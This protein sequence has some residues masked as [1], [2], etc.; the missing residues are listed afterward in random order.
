MA[1]I[2]KDLVSQYYGRA[3]AY[4]YFSGCSTGGRQGITSAVEYPGDFDGILAGA[5]AL[6]LADLSVAGYWPQFVMHHEGVY[7]HRCEFDAILDAEIAACDGLDGVEDGIISDPDA[8]V[9]DPETLVGTTVQC[10]GNLTEGTPTSMKISEAA[11]RIAA[12]IRRGPTSEGGAPLFV[13]T[14][15][16]TPF[17]GLLAA[18]NTNCNG[19]SCVGEPFP[20]VVDWIRLLVHRNAKYDLGRMS[21]RDLEETFVLSRRHLG[22][23]FA[24]A[25]NPDLSGFGSGNSSDG[26]PPRRMISWHGLADQ[27][28]TAFS[29]RLYYDRVLAR[30]ANAREYYRHFEAPGVHHC[31]VFPGK[32]AFYP[33]HALDA[34]VRWVEQ[35]IAPDVLTGYHLPEGRG[36]IVRDPVETRPICMYPDV[37]RYVG[38]DPNAYGSFKCERRQANLAKEEVR[39]RIRDEL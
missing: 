30:D 6:N 37:L 38:G 8:C 9:F 17:T 36:K 23:I 10:N 32:P 19:A 3:P 1:T 31:G 14:P 5:P 2:G 39:D 15:A 11:A 33:L 18:A 12:R 20:M 35:Q 26:R 27:T 7:P 34:L 25:T 4:S 13:G 28:I 24:G 22:P 16:G 21:A 29:S